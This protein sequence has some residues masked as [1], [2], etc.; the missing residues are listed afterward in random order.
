MTNMFVSRW[1]RG[2]AAMPTFFLRLIDKECVEA[3][4]LR[5]D[6]ASAEDAIEEARIALAELARE[7][8]PRVPGGTLAVEVLNEYHCPIKEVRLL[9]QEIDRSLGPATRVQLA[10]SREEGPW[11]EDRQQ[12]G[13]KE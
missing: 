2:V 5:Y 1:N 6:C 7:G 9:V 12:Q 4:D 13:A 3:G 10:R 8:L 11:G